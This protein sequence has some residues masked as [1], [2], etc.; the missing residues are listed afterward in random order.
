MF[1]T[2]ENTNVSMFSF[3]ACVTVFSSSGIIG[4]AFVC[5]LRAAS[6]ILVPLVVQHVS[7]WFVSLPLLVQQHLRAA[8]VCNIAISGPLLVV[9]VNCTAE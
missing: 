7:M 3:A 9:F 2:C 4:A 8:V 6:C 5:L 1:W